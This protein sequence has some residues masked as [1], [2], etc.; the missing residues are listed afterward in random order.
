MTTIIAGRFSQQSNATE[1]I[2]LLVESGFPPDQMTSFFLNEADHSNPPPLPH[3]VDTDNDK[4]PPTESLATGAATTAAGGG[5]IGMAV[6]VITAPLLGPA[7]IIAGAA[8]GAYIGALIG[9]LNNMEA[10]D[11]NISQ[12]TSA[13]EPGSS[14]LKKPDAQKSELHKKEPVKSG[15]FVAVTAATAAKQTSAIQI[16]RAKNAADIARAEGSIRAGEW[17]D[18][19]PLAP[20]ILIDD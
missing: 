10:G 9:A 17:M 14:D 7:A 19:D 12:E 18:F 16:L 6:G 8:A 3:D 15:I 1:A 2:A 5:G 4:V 20:I 11:A 13:L